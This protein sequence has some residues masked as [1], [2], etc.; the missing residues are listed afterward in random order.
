[1]S[2]VSVK[3]KVDYGQDVPWLVRTYVLV[4]TALLGIG[5][6]FIFKGLAIVF[7]SQIGKKVIGNLLLDGLR[8]RGDETVLDVGCGRGLLLIGAAKRLPQGRVLGIDL[9]S[10]ID[11]GNNSKQ[12]TV[13]NAVL[14]GVRDRIEVHDGDMRSLP[15][16][17]ASVDV[18]VASQSIHNIPT[19]EGRLTALREIDRVLKPGGKIAF[20][21]VF[22]V[23]EYGEDLQ[24]L[25]MQDVHVSGPSLWMSPP[26][27]TVTARK[28]A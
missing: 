24:R 18:V 8:L 16:P 23:K 26:F 25:G 6:W 1:M 21:D 20:M 17:N 14:E 27:R 28:P 10:Q 5:L 11:Q 15:F 22:C 3:S 13:A 9:W 4:G 7:I 12:A 2:N 19:R